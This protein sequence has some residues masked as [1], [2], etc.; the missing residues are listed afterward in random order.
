MEQLKLAALDAD[1]LEIVSAH[2]QDAVLQVGAID[3]RAREKRFLIEMNRFVWEKAGGL[4]RRHQ[5]R[6]RSVLHFDR[7]VAVRSTGIDRTKPRE[8]LS[9]LTIGFAEDAAPAGTIE[10][11]FAGGG[12][13]A[14]DVECVEARLTDL[15]A[16]WA[17]SS[18]PEHGT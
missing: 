16:A 15:G 2:V 17:A 1:D 5:E 8:T 13:I 10:L 7:V 18:R 4:F 11:L 6:R 3:W 9:L 14:L 12:S